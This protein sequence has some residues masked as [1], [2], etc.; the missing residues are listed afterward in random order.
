MC[1]TNLTLCLNLALL[2]KSKPKD[3]PLSYY[4][5]NTLKLLITDSAAIDSGSN[6]NTMW[7]L[8]SKK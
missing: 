3:S 4:V 8:L 2:T 5:P 6:K 1:L 7:K